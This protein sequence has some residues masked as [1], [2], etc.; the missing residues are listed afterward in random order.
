MHVSVCLCTHSLF[1]YY[2]GSNGQ[3]AKIDMTA[4][5]LVDVIENSTYTVYFYLPRLYQ[6][7]VPPQA[8]L[9]DIVEVKLPEQKY[10][11]VRRYGGFVD[12]KNMEEVAS[13]KKGLQGTPYQRAAAVDRFTVAGYNS[14]FDITNR[15]NEVFL[16]FD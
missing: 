8:S 11:A 10:A 14:P 9:A 12:D 5:V 7:G 1:E 15:V 16:R 4:P 6:S 3:H 13:L 2:N